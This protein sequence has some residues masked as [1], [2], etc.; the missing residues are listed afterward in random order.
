MKNE[1]VGELEDLLKEGDIISMEVDLRSKES[2]KRTLHFFI[3][4]NQQSL[5]FTELPESVEFGVF[6]YF[7]FCMLIDF[8]LIKSILFVFSCLLKCRIQLLLFF[9]LKNSNVLVQDI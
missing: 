8:I 2:G 1:T 3:N 6:L 7:L 5:F 9:L 4:N